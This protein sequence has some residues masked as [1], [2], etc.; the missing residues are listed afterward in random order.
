MLFDVPRTQRFDDDRLYHLV[1]LSIQYFSR[2]LKCVVLIQCFS[3][4]INSVPCYFRFLSGKLVFFYIRSKL[5]RLSVCIADTKTLLINRF[6]DQVVG[7][8]CSSKENRG[9]DRE[10]LLVSSDRD[11]EDFKENF[12]RIDAYVA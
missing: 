3:G 6:C 9:G 11:F 7:F 12:N 8:T 1:F 4:F 5:A 2:H 10:A